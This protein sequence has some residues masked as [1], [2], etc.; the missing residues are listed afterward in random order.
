V[1][2]FLRRSFRV[3]PLRVN[4]STS[5]VGYSMSFWFLTLGRNARGRW[6]FRLGRWG[7]GYYDE[8]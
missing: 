4:V 5:G 7:L 2:F 8:L 1:G 6:Y 3:G